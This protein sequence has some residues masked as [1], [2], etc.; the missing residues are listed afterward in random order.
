MPAGPRYMSA[1]IVA[2]GRR[3]SGGSARFPHELCSRSRRFSASSRGQYTSRSSC[4]STALST[5]DRLSTP[6]GSG[7]GGSG[8]RPSSIGFN[9]ADTAPSSG[10]VPASAGLTSPLCHRGRIV[11]KDVQFVHHRNDARHSTTGTTT[12]LRL[13]GRELARAQQLP[14]PRPPR[15]QTAAPTIFVRQSDA[16]SVGGLQK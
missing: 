13:L 15:A 16:E 11:L 6:S 1:S 2:I 5:P 8:R 3:S 10:L 7:T 9:R 14:P 12:K 4:A